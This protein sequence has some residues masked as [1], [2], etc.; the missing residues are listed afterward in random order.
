MMAETLPRVQWRAENC[1][2]RAVEARKAQAWTGGSRFGGN[3]DASGLDHNVFLK[4]KR[5]GVYFKA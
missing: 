5:K 1:K 2:K 4:N 3:G